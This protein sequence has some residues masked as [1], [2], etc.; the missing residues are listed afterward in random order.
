MFIS[1][2][3]SLSV[4]ELHNVMNLLSWIVFGV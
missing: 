1:I 3:I 4:R 2:L